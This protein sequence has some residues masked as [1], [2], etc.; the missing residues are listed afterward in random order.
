[1]PITHATRM[2]EKVHFA[3]KNL[4]HSVLKLQ[5]IAQ[6]RWGFRGLVTT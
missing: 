5:K 1:M 3:T 4:L 6:L 2:E